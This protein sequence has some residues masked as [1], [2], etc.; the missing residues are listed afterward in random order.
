[1]TSSRI[2]EIEEAIM[3]VLRAEPT[4]EEQGI[5]VGNELEPKAPESVWNY[6]A[7]TSRE[8]RGLGRRPPT[9]RED[10]KC[11]LRIRV[12]SGENFGVVKARAWE[13]MDLVETALR[14]NH[15]LDRTVEFSRIQKAIG[16]PV[17]LDQRTGYHI[18]FQL[19]AK[20]RI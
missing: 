10:I 19:A 6:K 9:L 8:F 18:L 3:E 13:L 11:F 1:M 16:E 20:T 2:P 14:D 4:L 7:E 5:E 15:K 17:S 12:V